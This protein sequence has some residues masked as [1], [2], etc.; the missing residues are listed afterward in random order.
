M[1]T[2]EGA[3]NAGRRPALVP[4]PLALG[5]HL[6]YN[7]VFRSPVPVGIPRVRASVPLASLG[8]PP[9]V[10]F[11]PCL[12]HLLAEPHSRY[13]RLGASS[14]GL[15]ANPRPTGARPVQSA[16]QGRNPVGPC[17]PHPLAVRRPPPPWRCAPGPQNRVNPAKNPPKTLPRQPVPLRGTGWRGRV[18]PLIPHPPPVGSPV[19]A[20]IM[21]APARQGPVT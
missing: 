3:A 5:I 13:F 1:N 11:L 10:D 18:P 14:P 7:Q 4:G 16:P 17:R 2:C 19:P 21:G 6:V 20:P 8:A 15:P 9:L 12:A